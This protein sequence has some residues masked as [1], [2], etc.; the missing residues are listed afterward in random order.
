MATKSASPCDHDYN[1]YHVVVIGAPWQIA[2]SA[3]SSRRV[4][5]SAGH[6]AHR[7]PV[8]AITDPIVDGF[9]PRSMASQK[10]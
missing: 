10:R 8:V 1:P 2:P 6:R 3:P 9:G 4:I 7:S 5:A